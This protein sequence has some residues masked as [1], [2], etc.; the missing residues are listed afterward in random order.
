LH[1]S[2][3]IRIAPLRSIINTL[4]INFNI[5]DDYPESVGDLPVPES[6]PTLP[7]CPGRPNGIENH[8]DFWLFVLGGTSVQHLMRGA[9]KFVSPESQ[10]AQ[11][12]A[13]FSRNY[14]VAKGSYQSR[15]PPALLP[16]GVLMGQ[17]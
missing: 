11:C 6:F 12:S 14:D 17:R 16:E 1:R 9:G 15:H 5:L 4:N 7:L 2:G 10:G 13:W 3:G 8:H